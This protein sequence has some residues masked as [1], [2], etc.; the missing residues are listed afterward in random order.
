MCPRCSG[1]LNP[2]R[3]Q[4]GSYQSCATCGYTRDLDGVHSNG[5]H[6]SEGQHQHKGVAS[7][8]IRYWTWK[9]KTAHKPPRT[10]EVTVQ[11]SVEPM[12]SDKTRQYGQVMAVWNWPWNTTYHNARVRMEADFWQQHGYR[13]RD[14]KAA[15][16]EVT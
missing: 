8:D 2:Q 15:I 3:D 7:P 10:V 14:L 16:E 12:R 11:Y 1:W 9:A 5:E 6:I 4:Y 13:L